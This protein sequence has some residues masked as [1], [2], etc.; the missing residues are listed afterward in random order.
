MGYVLSAYIV[1]VDHL[2]SVVGSGD[3][4]LLKRVIKSNPDEFDGQDEFPEGSNRLPLAT[5][6]Q[7]IIDGQPLVEREYNQYGYALEELCRY[8]GV[9]CLADRWDIG[10][11]GIDRI[12]ETGPPVQLP[13]REGSP[14]IG[15]LLLS[16]IESELERVEAEAATASEEHVTD[17]FAEWSRCLQKASKTG[18]DVLLFYG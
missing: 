12:L 1:S 18:K 2:R 3:T 11:T 9:V 6:L 10:S 8:L 5:A 14:K 17:F 16:E 13:P 4:K 7:H 15:V